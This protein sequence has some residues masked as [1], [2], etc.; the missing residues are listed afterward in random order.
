MAAPGDAL[1]M[2]DAAQRLA[3]V[4]VFERRPRA[5]RCSSGWRCSARRAA[6]RG[7]RYTAADAEQVE[8]ARRVV[9][10]GLVVADDERVALAAALDRPEQIVEVGIV[11]Q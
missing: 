2:I 8:L 5:K 1:F 9:D 11:V 10:L 7:P 4:G 6:V 3:R